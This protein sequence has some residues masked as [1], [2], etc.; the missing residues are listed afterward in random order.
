MRTN[1]YATGRRGRCGSRAMR[2]AGLCVAAMAAGLSGC[3][4]T[5]S[6][7]ADGGAYAQDG[8]TI[9]DSSRT[10]SATGKDESAIHVYGGGS[11]TATGA[12]AYAAATPSASERT[13]TKTGDMSSEDKSNFYGSNAIVLA[14]SASQI[15]LS[16]FVLYS[17]ATGANGAFAYGANSTV[18]VDHSW[19]ITE[20]D[21]SRGVD[22][23]YGGRVDITNS[24]ISTKGAH[25]AALAS[26]RYDSTPP[27]I[28]ADHVTG[29][30]AGEGSPGIYC[31]GTFTVSNS[32][33]TATGSEAAV[34]EGLNS[35]TLTDSSLTG[36]TKWGVFVYQSMSGDSAVGT[37]TF[38][39]TGGSMTNNSSGPDFMICN[40]TAVINLNG[41]TLQHGSNWSGTLLRATSASSGDANI[42]SGWGTLGGTVTLNARNQALTGAITRYSSASSITLRLYSGSTWTMTGDSTVDTLIVESG[43]TVNKS[44]HTLTNV[45]LTNNG[46]TINP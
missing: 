25:C 39:M 46:G 44:G 43:A 35:I 42:N 18:T 36:S 19:I 38:S 2:A 34:I 16:N 23:T 11:Y 24:S 9:V 41:V 31:T 21:S 33:L 7:S 27:T 28:V 30:T 8:N 40:T 12:Y 26:D 4:S 14:E 10:Y 32:T 37:G 15:A 20:K 6:S 17:S 1:N 5:A 22:A 29:T 13:A 3:G 45:T